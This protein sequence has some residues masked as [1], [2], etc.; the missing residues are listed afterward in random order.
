MPDLIGGQVQASF[1]PIVQSIEYIK[2]GKL[3][4]LALTSATRS[5]LLPG[6]P[7]AAEFVPGYEAT[8][9]D[10][11]GAPARTPM[12]IVGE[13]NKAIN[14]VLSDPAMKER[15]AGL[16]AEPMP[17]TP[18]ALGQYIAGETGKWA[19]VVKTAHIKV[20]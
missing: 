10:A 8:V 11:L 5:D 9:W 20:E 18:A 13:L 3:R 14:A 4:A 12:E 16:G 15:F 6:V 7:A 1:P 17:M 2:A 19:K